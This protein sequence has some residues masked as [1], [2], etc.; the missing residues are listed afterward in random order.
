LSV[1]FAVVASDGGILASLVADQ[2]A[3]SA[4]VAGISFVIYILARLVGARVRFR[5]RAVETAPAVSLRGGAAR[6]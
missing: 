3:P 1:L 5:R 4:F 2:V 6:P